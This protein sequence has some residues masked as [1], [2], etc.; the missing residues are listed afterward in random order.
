MGKDNH[1]VNSIGAKY[2]M[3]VQAY[4][5]T[6]NEWFAAS[7]PA[8]DIMKGNLTTTIAKRHGK[9][10]IQVAL[11][12]LTD[13]GMPIMI[14]TTNPTYM[15]QNLDLFDW[16]LSPTETALLDAH[17]VLIPYNPVDVCHTTGNYSVWPENAA[18]SA[19]PQ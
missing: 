13:A 19:I 11:K 8:P 5:V 17:H 14:K 10:P 12:W 4:S 3:V 9:A 7:G 6:G 1:H 16:T 18:D 2:G 15:K